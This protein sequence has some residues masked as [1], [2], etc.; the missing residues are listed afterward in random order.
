[1]TRLLPWQTGGNCRCIVA[2]TANHSVTINGDCDVSSQSL[3]AHGRSNGAERRTIATIDRSCPAGS[4]KFGQPKSDAR[5]S[6]MMPKALSAVIVAKLQ[7][8]RPARNRAMLT[9]QP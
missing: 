2:S 7:K 8:K 5:D 4:V 1:M 9:N 3:W 6:Q